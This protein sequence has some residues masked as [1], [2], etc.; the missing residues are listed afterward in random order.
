MLEDSYALRR[1]AM[2]TIVTQG[3]HP[4]ERPGED[5]GSA[6]HSSLTRF[7]IGAEEFAVL[8]IPAGSPDALE[9]LTPAER[10]IVQIA[11][12]GCSNREIAK[13]RATAVRTVANQLTAIYRKLGI[14]SRAELALRC[15]VPPPSAPPKAK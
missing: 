9:T 1:S 6:A 14:G 11:L 7:S 3:P 8:S 5:K 4:L 10:R 12:T 15:S 13:V 2:T